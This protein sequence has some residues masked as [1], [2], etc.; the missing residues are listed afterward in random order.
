LSVEYLPGKFLPK[1]LADLGIR[2]VVEQALADLGL[3]LDDIASYEV[4][5]ALGN[6]GLGRLAACFLDSLAT[7]SYP[8]FGYGIRYQVGMFSQS[9]EDGQQVEHPEH[10]LRLGDPWQFRRPSIAYTVRF[11]G[12][13]E[14]REINSDARRWVDTEDVTA[15]AFD[16]PIS[17]YLSETAL[18]LR[19]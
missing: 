6:G 11:H 3:S 15:I 2:D 16:L 18:Y 7:H 17:G 1:S 5:T 8:G 13:V 14:P 9:I 12:R 10:W 4:E 19:L